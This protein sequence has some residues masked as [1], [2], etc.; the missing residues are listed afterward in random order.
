VA[1]LKG[2]IGQSGLF[3][4]PRSIGSQSPD[5]YAYELIARL[6]R[7]SRSSEFFDGSVPA[8]LQP[9]LQQLKQLLSAQETS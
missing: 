5:G 3:G 7:K 1:E 8:E 4:L 6:N 2:L 9:L